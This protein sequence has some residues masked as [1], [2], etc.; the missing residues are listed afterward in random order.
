MPHRR[1]CRR[2]RRV[3]A[4]ALRSVAGGDEPEAR[5]RACRVRRHRHGARLGSDDRRL[6]GAEAAQ[7]LVRT[8]GDGH[9]DHRHRPGRTPG[10]RGP[11]LELGSGARHGS[12]RARRRLDRNARL[13]RRSHRPRSLGRPGLRQHHARTAD[14]LNRNALPRVAASEHNT[15]RVP[16]A[17]VSM[18]LSDLEKYLPERPEPA[19]FAAFWAENLAEA[20][21]VP[22]ALETEPVDT[23]LTTVTV[24]DVTFPG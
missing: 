13:G 18:A 23:G 5:R 2:A 9:R 10:P 22:A 16:M 4:S 20:R 15:P 1:G 17:F 21:S 24:E 11:Q 6:A 8:A 12:G 7:R 3:R 14:R 19:D